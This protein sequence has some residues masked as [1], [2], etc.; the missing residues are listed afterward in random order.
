M[1]VK[2]G[3]GLTGRGPKL[4]PLLPSLQCPMLCSSRVWG[5][6]GSLQVLLTICHQIKL[7]A[8]M[9]FLCLSYRFCRGTRRGLS[10]E[11]DHLCSRVLWPG[12]W[13]QTLPLLCVS[14][15]LL[16]PQFSSAGCMGVTETPAGLVALVSASC[17][18]SPPPVPSSQSG[19]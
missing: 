12:P 7:L 4:L 5:Q 2:P 16:T 14:R 1:G 15:D 17:V 18:P 8:G 13:A 19:K 6:H 10:L 3:V 9:N 11:G